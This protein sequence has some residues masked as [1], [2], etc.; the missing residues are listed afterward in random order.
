[1]GLRLGLGL[2]LMYEG[3]ETRE[4]WAVRGGVRVV[5]RVEVRVEVRVMVGVRVGV[6]ARVRVRV[7][8]INLIFAS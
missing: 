7:R 6:S 8:V 5:V 2:V 1:L 4:G 3:N